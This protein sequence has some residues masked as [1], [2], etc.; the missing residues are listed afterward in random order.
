MLQLLFQ[1]LVYVIGP[2]LLVG[3]F[4]AILYFTQWHL[5]GRRLGFS[6]I[7]NL[8]QLT[9]AELLLGLCQ[10]FLVVSDQVADILLLDR[11]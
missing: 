10:L 7:S 3:G 2:Q 5:L 9:L 8:S 4:Q 6:K 1:L 11:D